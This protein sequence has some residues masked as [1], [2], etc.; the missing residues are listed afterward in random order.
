MV[1]RMHAEHNRSY[2]TP[3]IYRSTITT[4][5]TARNANLLVFSDLDG[6]LL[7]HDTYSYDAAKPALLQLLR[8]NIPLILNTSKTFTETLNL[9]EQI[10]IF[11]PFI[12]E[13][14]SAIAIPENYFSTRPDYDELIEIENQSPYFIKRFG[15]NYAQICTHL[16]QLRNKF[17]FDF[18]GFADMSAQEV[19]QLTG[20]ELEQ[21]QDSRKRMACEP[22]VWSGGN[23]EAFQQQLA[24][25]NLS[26]VQGGRFWHVKGQS[27]KAQAMHYLTKIYQNQSPNQHFLQIALGDSPNDL[28]MLDEADIA[29]AIRSYDGQHRL[30]LGRLKPNRIYTQ[31]IGPAGW[32]A[33]LLRVIEHYLPKERYYG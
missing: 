27:N 13:N 22:I 23:I 31:N 25:H 21:A 29:I 28:T 17:S 6:T 3:P 5:Q 4:T 30:N 24:K 19:A 2:P 9:I 16:R 18:R 10:S 26:L 11:H 14:G 12:I 8:H 7:D 15:P 32:Q 20:L 33:A 1:N